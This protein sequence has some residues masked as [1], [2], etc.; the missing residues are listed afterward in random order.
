MERSTA[1]IGAMM[2]NGAKQENQPDALIALALDQSLPRDIR[3]VAGE[4]LNDNRGAALGYIRTLNDKALLQ[5]IA[6]CGV[7]A[8]DFLTFAKARLATLEK[9]PDMTARVLALVQE[10]NDLLRRLAGKAA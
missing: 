5:K 3:R 6:R 7:I 9:E 1:A 10:Q 2:Y 4:N 8:N